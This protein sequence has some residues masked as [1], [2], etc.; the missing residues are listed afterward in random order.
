MFI[1]K[2]FTGQSMMRL[3]ST[4]PDTEQRIARLQRLA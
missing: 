3:F 4:H 2:P 1:I